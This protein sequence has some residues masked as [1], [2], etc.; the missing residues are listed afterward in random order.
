MLNWPSSPRHLLERCIMDHVN[1]T[2]SK[3]LWRV[4]SGTITNLKTNEVRSISGINANVKSMAA[5]NEA[6]FVRK[7][8]E[9]FD[10]GTWPV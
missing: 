1:I 7:C 10:S 9:A 2:D 8:R 3:N 6:T 5:M 4:N